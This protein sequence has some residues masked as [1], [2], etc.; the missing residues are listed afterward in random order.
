MCSHR[1]QTVGERYIWFHIPHALASVAT[2]FFRAQEFVRS[3]MGEN[4]GES[5]LG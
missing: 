1:R 3:R 4:L 5:R 2:V